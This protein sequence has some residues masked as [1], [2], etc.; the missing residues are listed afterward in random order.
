[1]L[2]P[3]EYA[4]PR[5]GGDGRFPLLEPFRYSAWVRVWLA[6]LVS[7][8]GDWMQIFAR[9]ALAYRLTGQ[10]SSVGWI[11]FASYLPQLLLSLWGGVL[12]DRFDRRRLLVG[13]QIAQMAGAVVMGVLV[14]TGTVSLLGIAA[15]S[16]AIGLAMAL[17]I[18]A[19]QALGPAVV[20]REALASAISFWTATGALCRVFGPVIAAALIGP[21]GLRW[22]FWINAISF[23][24]VIFAW[25]TTK[26]PR[27]PRLSGDVRNLDAMREAARYVRGNARVWVPICVSAFLASVGIV[28]Q[29]LIIPF[30]TRVLSHG[31]RHL[32][33]SRAGW[34]QAAIGFGAAVGIL[35]LASV[36]RRRPGVTLMGSALVFSASLFALGRV[37]SFA[38][39]MCVCFVLGAMQFT[40][41][42]LAINLVQHDVPEAMRGRVMSIQMMGLIG[43][44]PIASL[45][46]GTIADHV[47]IPMLLS[48]AGACCAVFSLSAVRWKRHVGAHLEPESVETIAAVGVVL[49]EEG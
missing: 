14:A 20:S 4:I 18:P 36:G 29:P 17:N 41:M 33:E 9:A 47:G 10:P 45:L 32:G 25:A 19:G 39:A 38:V 16:F 15:V 30:A 12:A 43:L 49:E 3:D 35:G 13:C 23:V 8:L 27:Q 48:G 26:V 6:G 44:V 2:T 1:V 31:A 24:A 46:G 28:Y 22:I 5:I 34:L 40:N 42:T 11:Y 37:S 21:I 7:Q